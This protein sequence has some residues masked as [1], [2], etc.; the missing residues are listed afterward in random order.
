MTIISTQYY[1]IFLQTNRATT[2][3]VDKIFF[4]K[5]SSGVHIKG[6]AMVGANGMVK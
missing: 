2:E 5:V 6:K 3:D 4:S 1:I